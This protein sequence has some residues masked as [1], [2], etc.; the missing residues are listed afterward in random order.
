VASQFPPFIAHAQ[1]IEEPRVYEATFLSTDAS[2]P[3]EFVFFDT[4]DNNVK[5]C[6]ADPALI[7]G[8]LLGNAPA[9]VLSQK[10]QPYGTN[11]A[12][13]AVLTADVVIG[14]SS[15]TTPSLAFVTRAGGLTKVTAGT[16]NF[17]QC[18]TSKTAG[19]SRFIIIDVDIPNGIFFVR[20]KPANLMG[21]AVVS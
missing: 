13:V 10:P 18:D 8:L 17:W 1:I 9:S 12:P 7:L 4:A 2:Q 3:F 11:K 14:L 5:T 20:F 19:T 16:R 21:Q 6:G 15:T